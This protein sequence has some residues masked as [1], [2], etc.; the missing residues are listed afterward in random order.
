MNG[1]MNSLLLTL[2]LVEGQEL[3]FQ[4]PELSC[5]QGLTSQPQVFPPN[6]SIVQTKSYKSVRQ[7]PYDSKSPD[8]L[9]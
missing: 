5:L 8:G 7:N 6:F 2:K 9:T 1:L 4:P 3:F